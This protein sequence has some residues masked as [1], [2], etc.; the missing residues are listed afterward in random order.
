MKR[1]QTVF[2]LALRYCRKDIEQL[3]AD[4][5]AESLYD[6]DATKFW[7]KVYKIIIIIIIIKCFC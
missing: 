1:T 5:C 6:K 3:K 4:A 7:N 2:K